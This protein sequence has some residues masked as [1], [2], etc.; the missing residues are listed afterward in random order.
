MNLVYRIFQF[1]A[2]IIVPFILVDGIFYIIGSFVAMDMDPTHWWV[3]THTVGRITF[4]IWQLVILANIPNFWESI[5][6]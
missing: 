3:F 6:L 5:D 2:W 1:I 4:S